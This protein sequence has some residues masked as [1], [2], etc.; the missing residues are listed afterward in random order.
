MATLYVHDI[1]LVLFKRIIKH[2]YKNKYLV[3]GDLSQSSSLLNLFQKV[4]AWLLTEPELPTVLLI[5]ENMFC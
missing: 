4:D 3:T 1:I 2:N 5:T